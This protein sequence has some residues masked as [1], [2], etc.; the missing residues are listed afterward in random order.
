MDMKE[1]DYAQRCHFPLLLVLV[2]LK[3]KD[4]Y[5]SPIRD[6][7]NLH[8]SGANRPLPE[9]KSATLRIPLWNSF[10]EERKRNYSGLRW[11]AVE[12]GRMYAFAT[13]ALISSMS[14]STKAGC[15]AIPSA[16]GTSIMARKMN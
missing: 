4:A 13:L 16:T 15:Q 2:D 7:V 12:P 11:Y 1:I 5:R 3:V 14:F 6:E 10:T 9:Q 8:L